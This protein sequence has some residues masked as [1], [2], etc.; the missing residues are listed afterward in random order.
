MNVTDTLLNENQ[1]LPENVNNRSLFKAV[2]E[3]VVAT[4]R[5]SK[6]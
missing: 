5:F 6:Q 1:A 3:Y 4:K 2:I